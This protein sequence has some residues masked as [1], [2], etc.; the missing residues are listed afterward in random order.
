[1]ISEKRLLEI[2]SLYK[3]EIFFYIFRMTSSQETAEDIAHDCFESLIK[4]SDKYPLEDVNLRSFLYKTAHNLT[5][6]YLKRENRYQ[7]VE[8][9]ESMTIDKLSDTTGNVEL[10]ELNNKIYEFLQ[11]ID[12]VSRS[13]FIMKKELKMDLIDIAEKLNISERTVRRKMNRLLEQLADTL[14]K[15]GFMQ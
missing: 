4:Y 15:S 10:D 2:Y 1:M 3:K 12:E 13:I 8:I 9:E 6:N 11:S 14:K 7:K 5:I